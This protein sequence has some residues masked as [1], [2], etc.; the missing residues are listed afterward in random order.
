VSF[1]HYEA[2]IQDRDAL[3]AKLEDAVASRRAVD[4]QMLSLSRK[5]GV[6]PDLAAS[7]LRLHAD[8][9]FQE[10]ARTL[11]ESRATLAVAR[12]RFGPRHPQVTNAVQQ[13]TGAEAQ[14]RS[15]GA[16]LLGDAVMS[17]S[18]ALDIAPDPARAALLAELVELAGLCENL[19][20]AETT[21]I[22]QRT[23]ADQRL[24]ILAPMASRLDDL[25]RDYQV[26]ETVFSSALARVDTTKSDVYAS[27]PLVQT[28]AD[29]SLPIKPTSPKP[30]IAIAA[31]IV[32]TLMLLMGLTLAWVRRPLIDKLLTR[33]AA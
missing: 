22:A 8:P 21:L 6:S 23:S 5:L 10:L 4:A 11:S 19:A 33:P 31:G 1:A 24:A 29:A 7:N 27:Y 2:L 25:S 32:A 17:D 30:L 12:G 15:R 28:L 14:M 9:E 13:L 18:A 3:I 16:A 20:S 26:A